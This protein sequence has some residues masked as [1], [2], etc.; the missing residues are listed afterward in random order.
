MNSLGKRLKIYYL[1]CIVIGV[2]LLLRILYLQNFK[3]EYRAMAEEQRTSIQELDP[4][5]GSILDSKGNPLAQT[6]KTNA[7]YLYPYYVNDEKRLI[8]FLNS[9][10]NISEASTRKMLESEDRSLITSNLDRKAIEKLARANIKG[11]KLETET[12]RYYP[13]EAFASHALGFMN[14]DGH[15]EYGLEAYYDDILYGQKGL[16]VENKS[17]SGDLIPY[18]KAN[19]QAAKKGSDIKLTIDSSIQDL[20]VKY[21]LKTYE[22]FSPKNLSI[23]VMDPNNGHILAMENFPTYDPNEPRK[24][25][26]EDFKDDKLSEEEI[27]NLAYQRWRNYSVND[28]YEPGSIYKVITAASGVEEGTIQDSTRFYCEGVV[29]NIPGVTLYCHVY[30][31]S[32]GEQNLNEAMANSCNPSFIQMSTDLGQERMFEYIQKFGFDKKTGIDLPAEAE[33]LVPENPAS[34]N[35]ASLATM[36]YGHGIA[37]S[38]IQVITAISAVVNGGDLY[39][40][41][42]VDEIIDGQTKQVQKIPDKLVR[43]VISQETSDIIKESLV[44]GVENGTADGAKIA[45][46]EIGG[47]TGTTEKIVDG[48]YSAD[49]SVASFVG[50]YPS[51]KPEFVVLAVA[52]EAQGATSGNVVTAPLVA[53]I[54]RALIEIRGD[55]PTA[56]LDEGQDMIDNQEIEQTSDPI[57]EESFEEEFSLGDEEE[58]QEDLEEDTDNSQ[59]FETQSTEDI[60]EPTGEDLQEDGF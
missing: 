42:L 16:S 55:Q 29:E 8:E 1:F 44:Y 51:D 59:E 24:A 27:T 28:V 10:L 52:D 60:S 2:A 18:E 34:I 37:L 58:S 50:V 39:Q 56:H 14:T 9:S 23:I 15:G 47:K 3:E 11:L 19:T 41:K 25:I 53:E 13:N 4:D 43:K 57:L 12:S 5:R 45:G 48:E 38:P 31:E 7:L 26:V 17:P 36:G 32:H 54:I 49:I 22:E 35:L 33:G 21:G 46:F 40:P 20:V 6:L 30:P